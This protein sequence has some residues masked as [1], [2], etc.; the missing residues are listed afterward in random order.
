MDCP[1]VELNRFS[2]PLHPEGLSFPIMCGRFTLTKDTKEITQRWQIGGM[3]V[4]VKPRYYIAPMQNVLI[5]TDDGERELVQMRWGLIPSRTLAST[6]KN[7]EI[8]VLSKLESS[9][10]MG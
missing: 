7:S 4:E 10:M 2:C 8:T 6:C 1:I 3:E 9:G 5:V